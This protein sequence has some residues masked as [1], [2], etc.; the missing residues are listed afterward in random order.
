MNFSPRS[1]EQ[2]LESTGEAHAEYARAY[3]AAFTR[4]GFIMLLFAA[5]IAA[6]IALVCH[7]V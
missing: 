2:E 5:G 7:C 6:W 4:D 3:R 1:T